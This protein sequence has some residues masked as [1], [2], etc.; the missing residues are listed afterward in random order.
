MNSQHYTTPRSGNPA[1]YCWKKCPST[2]ILLAAY[3]TW[4]ND[5]VNIE[6]SLLMLK[7]CS[8]IF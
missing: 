3:D 5:N 1:I 4:K 6:N 8:F 2:T 7:V